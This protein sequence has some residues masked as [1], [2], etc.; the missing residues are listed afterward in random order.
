MLILFEISIKWPWDCWFIESVKPEEES[1]NIL[2]S[3]L[4]KTTGHSDDI[5]EISS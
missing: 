3:S 2:S 5:L 4:L 1:E